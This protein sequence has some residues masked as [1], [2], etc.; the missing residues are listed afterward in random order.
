MRNKIHLRTC[1]GVEF[2]LPLI[3]HFIEHYKDLG[4]GEFYI[5]LSSPTEEHENLE[6]Q[7]Q[8]QMHLQLGNSN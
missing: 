3:R 5:T 8:M 1:V 4:V 2:D 7:M 6:M